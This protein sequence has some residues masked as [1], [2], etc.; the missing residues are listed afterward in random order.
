MSCR[1]VLGLEIA[2]PLFLSYVGTFRG[3][4]KLTFTNICR[5]LITTTT[6]LQ[7][8]LTNG[9]SK[10]APHVDVEIEKIVAQIAK[11]GRVDR[12]RKEAR[13]RTKS[14]P[15]FSGMD[16]SMPGDWQDGDN[17]DDA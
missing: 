4:C 11:T 12:L 3:Y 1:F 2:L 6:Y 14:Q 16:I 17:D 5:F 8:S 9:F 15:D 7:R 13:D 10:Y